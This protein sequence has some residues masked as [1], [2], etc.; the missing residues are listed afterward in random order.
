MK[1]KESKKILIL[2]GG[3]GGI[4]VAKDL[5]RKT[6][7]DIS[8]ELISKKSYFEYYPGLYRL[9][10]GASP[11]EV[12]VPLHQILPSRVAFH[13]ETILNIDL[14]NKKITTNKGEHFFDILIIAL[15]SKTTYFNLPGVDTLSLS[16]KSARE[17]LELRDHIYELFE[18]HAHPS[19]QELVSHFHVVIVGGGPSGVEVAGDLVAFMKRLAK[20][21]RL[22]PSLVTIDLIESNPRLLSTL[23]RKVGERVE[24]RL[25]NLG[26]NIF[27]NRKLASQEIEE[28][29]LKDMS[30]K[31]KTVI[32]TAGTELSEV[33]QKIDGI[34]FTPK[35]RIAVDLT[36]QIEGYS[37]IYAIGDV[38]GTE[39]SGLAQTAIYDAKFVAQAI[40][41]RILNKKTEKYISKKNAFIIP[42]GDDWGVFV[43][44]KFVIYG[45]VAYLMRHI[46]DFMYFATVVSPRKLFSLFFEGWK[47]RAVK[48][49]KNE[50]VCE[51]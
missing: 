30:L 46:V 40:S 3:F 4:R 7:K 25:R 23:P 35:K 16:F 33:V 13:I 38:A 27:L 50:G 19:E 10:T 18:T 44:G 24:K 48:K 26:V 1:K 14:K 12:C 28:V 37:D 47:Y 29:Y 11:I 32:W 43:F 49:R 39:Y 36:M 22:E 31:S 2:G 51:I 21:S 15:G 45:R 34:S 17:A 41:D 20:K 6:S 5:A 9:V 42:V 8:I